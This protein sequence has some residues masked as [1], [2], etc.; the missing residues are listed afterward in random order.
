[1][2]QDPRR[3]TATRRDTRLRFEQ[4]VKNPDCEANVVSAVAGIPMAKVAVSEGLEPTMGQSPFAIARG[5]TFER[6]LLA[7]DA[8][9]LREALVK[10]GV[11]PGRSRGFLDLRLT[12]NG[13]PIATLDGASAKTA[14]LLRQAATA[15][16]KERSTLPTIVTGAT[17]NVP[18]QPV[19]LPEGIVCLDVLTLHDEGPDAP[20]LLRVGEV[21][22]YP[23]RGGYTDAGELATARAQGGVYLHA[24]ALVVKDLG[25]QDQLRLADD[26]FLVLSRPGSNFPR[27]RAGESLG[28][29]ARRAER[30]FDRLRKAAREISPFDSSDEKLAISIV[31]NAETAYDQTC[32]SFC[33]RAPA[34][35]AQAAKQG[36]PSILGDEANRFLGSTD[37]DRAVALFK[38]A[39]PTTDVEEDLIRRYRELGGAIGP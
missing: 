26:G 18:G 35:R 22:T 29:Q 8:K 19:M 36:D 37:I 14:E 16:P 12:M 6:T 11:L 1:M 34:C 25:L 15:K 28:F 23:D 5:T 17:L 9:R 30:G 24:L 38:G 39:A 10:E 21:K 33:D 7:D 32:L 27:I 20:L 31:S 3:K 13:G 2:R 4:W